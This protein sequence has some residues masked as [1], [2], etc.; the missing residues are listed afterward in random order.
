MAIAT[1]GKIRSTI[2]AVFL[3]ATS[4][5]GPGFLTQT[6]LFTQQLQASLAFVIVISIIIDIIAQLNIWRI[7]AVTERYAQDIAN[8]VLPGLGYVIAALVVLGGLIFN[9]GNIAGAGLAI[10]I[11]FPGVSVVIGVAIS[12][13]IAVLIFVIKDATRI[14][15]YFILILGVVLICLMAYVAVAS[16]PPVVEA[17][18]AIVLPEKIGLMAII[19]LVGGTV[20]GYITYAGGHRLLEAGIKGKASMKLVTRGAISAITVASVIRVLLFLAALGVVSQGYRL[21]PHDPAGS[22]FAYATGVIGYKFFGC[23]LWAASI[24]SV[25]G[26]AYTSVSFIQTFNKWCYRYRNTLI[27]IFIVFSAVVFSFVGKPVAV[28]VFAGAAN[29]AI[30][31]ITL[32][33][34]LI[35]VHKPKIRKGYKHP[36]WLTFLGLFI[37]IVMSYISVSVIVDVVS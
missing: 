6:T 2:G 34:M 20:G 8:T 17:L 3:M 1:K 32:F 37:A 10:H 26:A 21:N 28:L 35:A 27:I 9:I 33:V 7:I 14:M 22:V 11:L 36:L 24:S 25:I 4:A 12:A 31:P 19:T 18:H 15:D 13:V 16:K 30:L 29:G 23:V 5:I